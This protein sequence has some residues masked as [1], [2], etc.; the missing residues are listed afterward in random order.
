VVA[1]KARDD[2]RGFSRYIYLWDVRNDKVID[3][4]IVK[5]VFKATGDLRI[6]TAYPASSHCDL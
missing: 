3:V 1:G 2:K 6:I 5:V 4:M